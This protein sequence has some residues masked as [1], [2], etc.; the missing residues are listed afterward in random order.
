MQYNYFIAY[1]NVAVAVINGPDPETW[2]CN[3]KAQ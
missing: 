2:R 3:D 1:Q